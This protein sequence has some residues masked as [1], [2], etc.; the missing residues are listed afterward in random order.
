VAYERNTET[1]ERLEA[2]GIEVVP[3]AGSELGSG[4]A[5]RAA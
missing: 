3:I 4:R 2:A 5:V 1:N